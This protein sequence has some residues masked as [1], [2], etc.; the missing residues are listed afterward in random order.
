M[1]EFIRSFIFSFF[2]PLFSVVYR[3][4]L[5]QVLVT[6]SRNL[7]LIYDLLICSDDDLSKETCGEEVEVIEKQILECV[8]LFPN[9]ILHNNR[10]KHIHWNES[11][12]VDSLNLF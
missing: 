1:K 8:Y 4:T 5:K 6:Y 12:I 2:P 10:T 7:A 9:N 11:L 3:N